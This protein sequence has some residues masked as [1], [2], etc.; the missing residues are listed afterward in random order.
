MANSAAI[1][2][3]QRV[4]RELR[5]GGHRQRL[6]AEIVVYV[7]AASDSSP[8]TPGRTA[9][10]LWEAAA[11]LKDARVKAMEQRRREEEARQAVAQEAA[12][13]KRLD[14][15]ATRTEAAWEKVTEWIGTRRPSDYDLAV[16]L[17]RDLQALAERDGYSDA[18]SKRFGELRARHER[19]PSLQERFDW[20]GLPA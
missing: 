11:D 3:G 19:K 4:S 6:A 17:L 7:P 15:L 8:A 14:Q 13:A 10:E 18:F 12:R 16:S 1:R 5:G 2:S 9:A 20:A